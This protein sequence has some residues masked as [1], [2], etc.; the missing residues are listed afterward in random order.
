VAAA[1]APVLL[2]PAQE[3]QL[4]DLSPPAA[5]P[6][7]QVGSLEVPVPPGLGRPDL[8]RSRADSRLSSYAPTEFEAELLRDEAAGGEDSE[9][10]EGQ[11]GG[12]EPGEEEGAGEEPGAQAQ[13][14]AQEGQRRQ[15]ARHVHFT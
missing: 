11:G 12:E 6:R 8:A 2:A 15:G 1:P 3:Q 10:E 7:P 5:P 9:Q 4:A 13:A 14:Q